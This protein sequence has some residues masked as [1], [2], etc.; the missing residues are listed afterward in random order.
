M[1]LKTFNPTTPGQRGLV[2]TEKSQLHKGKPV[3]M[4]KRA[5][6]FVALSDVIDVVSSDVIRFV[7][8]TRR[9]D[10]PIEFDYAKV[11]EKSRENPVFYV[12][13]AHA[14]ARSV[15][16]QNKKPSGEVNLSLLTDINEIRVIK[17]LSSWPKHVEAATYYCEPHRIAFYL[18]ELASVFHGLWNAGRENIDLKFIHDTD[19]DLTLA[20]MLLVEAT[21]QIIKSGLNLL[22][23]TA[24]EEM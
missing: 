15:L 12:Q 4:S 5:G 20:R 22:S 21:A 1:A 8:L 11:T 17:Q 14:R 16:R 6:T 19:D 2:L 10:Q 23:I 18:M 3:K 24:V 13:Y 7:M 9:N